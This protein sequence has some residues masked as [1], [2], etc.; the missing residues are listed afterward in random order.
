MAAG[1]FAGRVA[2]ERSA[3]LRIEIFEGAKKPGAKILVSG[4]GRCN[5]T[6]ERVTLEDFWG[7]P[8][9]IIKNVLR[10]FDE[11]QTLQWFEELG[12]AL[13]LEPTSKYFPVS[14]SARTVLQALFAELE[15]LNVPLHKAHRVANIERNAEGFIITFQDDSI[16]PV[17]ARRIIM[18]TGGL[19]L[20]KS[21]SDGAG[22]HWMRKLG[23]EI[24]PTTPALVPLLLQE[25][26]SKSWTNQFSDL[27]GVTLSLTLR[28]KSA[29]GKVLFEQRESTLFTH[30]GISGPGPMN[31]SRHWLRTR[32][33][34]EGEQVTVSG[35]FDDL[36]TQQQADKW[37]LEQILLQPKKSW[38]N[39]L[40]EKIPARLSETIGNQFKSP[41][42]CSKKERQHLAHELSNFPLAV[43]KDRGY[44]FAE[45]TAGGVDLRE[46]AWKTMEARKV[47]GLHLC[48]EIL[49]V[50][51]R[52]GG[53]NFQ[54]AWASGYLAGRAAVKNLAQPDG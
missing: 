24:I 29:T 53:F 8:R 46:I 27:S 23:L 10:S 9:T 45:T 48:G 42:E 6:N 30:W 34:N 12:V 43:Q 49:D 54:W 1:I 33:E 38:K 21:G 26:E 39:I 17:R 18:A 50:D 22:L 47:D 13:K 44:T 19:A 35:A 3:D 31:L 32:L 5:V 7:G 11:K 36:P 41:A 28:L 40:V 20:P 15:R 2:R 4:G 25:G 51:G 16:E 14:D 52:I 37:L